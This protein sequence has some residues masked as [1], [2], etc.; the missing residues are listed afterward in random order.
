MNDPE[1][2]AEPALDFNCRLRAPGAPHPAA[3][4]IESAVARTPKLREGPS[5]CFGSG[6]WTRAM[7]F[8]AAPGGRNA[9]AVMVQH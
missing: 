4:E 1:L 5:L 6:A 8:R 2:T 9:E 3:T 7:E